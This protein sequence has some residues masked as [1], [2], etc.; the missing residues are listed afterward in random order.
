MGSTARNDWQSQPREA[1]TGRWAARKREQP[2][3]ETIKIRLTE[4]EKAQI[5]REAARAGQTL[6]SW[7]MAA[8]AAYSQ[9]EEPPSEPLGALALLQHIA[10]ARG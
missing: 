8:A 10:R 5:E 9:P 7:L 1:A 2:R 4:A 6:T 3:C